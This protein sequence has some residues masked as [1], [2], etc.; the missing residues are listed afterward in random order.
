MNLLET[1]APKSDQLN[2]DDLIA[3]PRTITITRVTVAI[4]EQPV[5]IYFDGDN[6]KPYKPGKSMRRVLVK[7]YGDK[8]ENL[9][10]QSLTLFL[11]PAVKWAGQAVGGIRISHATGLQGPLTMALTESKGARKLFTVKPMDVH[12]FAAEL[13]TL[14][15]SITLDALK[16]AWLALSPSAQK[17][18]KADLE[19][20]KTSLT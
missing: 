16:S 5:S 12:P 11:D 13:K 20:I 14:A 18:L 10:G 15:D 9:V 17:A 4:G 2:A 6:G 1:I 7:L 19:R 8:A 3:G